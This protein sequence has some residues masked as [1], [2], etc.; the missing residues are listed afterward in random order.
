MRKILN[1]RVWVAVLLF[2]SA[3]VLLQAKAST[4]NAL[5]EAE[6]IRTISQS[7][8]KNYFYIEQGI[9]ASTA[10]KA[11]KEDMLKL[12]D[13]LGKLK[14]NVDTAEQKAIV[15]FMG[16]SR[17]ELV[18]L[19]KKEHN[20]EN[21][22]LVLDYTETLLEGSE[23][24]VNKNRSKVE[25]PLDTVK[26]MSFLLE[27]MSKYYIAFR[28]GYTDASNV[29]QAKKAVARFDALLEKLKGFHFPDQ[30][31][32]D[33]LKK[34]LKYW[35]TSKNFYLGIKKSDLPTIV[36][37]STKHMQSA[38]DEIAKYEE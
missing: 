7:L 11:F 21:G 5:L 22:G 4:K 12:G 14:Q 3:S 29:A 27:R 20:K 28:A 25:T 33:P 8:A 15:E 10:K 26:E 32:N 36:F 17:D 1:R 18:E 35:P 9:Q 34:L 30:I 38:L 13:I 6:E 24:I 2:A 31:K 37:I 16:M 23:N 19:A